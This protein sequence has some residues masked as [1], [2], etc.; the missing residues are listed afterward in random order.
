MFFFLKK[1]MTSFS[2]DED[3][4]NKL[5]FWMLLENQFAGCCKS[6]NP[7]FS[8]S[9]E[10]NDVDQKGK[11]SAIIIQCVC[12][13]LF[14]QSSNP[15]ERF[16]CER[17][18][19]LEKEFFTILKKPKLQVSP[20]Y[21][22]PEVLFCYTKKTSVIAFVSEI[23]LFDSALWIHI[24]KN[25][26]LT[27]VVQKNL[28]WQQLCQVFHVNTVYLIVNDH[29]TKFQ[30]KQKNDEVILLHNK[31]TQQKFSK[32]KQSNICW[33][34][35]EKFYV[36][37]STCASAGLGL[38]AKVHFS[39]GEIMTQFHGKTCLQ[40]EFEKNGE[41]NDIQ[42]EYSLS[43]QR[44]DGKVV[45]FDP[46]VCGKWNL[47]IAKKTRNC[48][49]FINEPP[50]H[51]LCNAESVSV[52]NKDIEQR[53]DIVATKNIS[54]HEEIFMLYNRTGHQQQYPV[55]LCCP[56][57]KNYCEKSTS[58]SSSLTKIKKGVVL[59]IGMTPMHNLDHL[60]LEAFIK[61]GWKVVCFSFL[62]QSN[63]DADQWDNNEAFIK[64]VQLKS[65]HLVDI[66]SVIQ[67]E[68][69][70]YVGTQLHIFF[71]YIHNLL[72][73]PQVVRQLFFTSCKD[74]L[75]KLGVT[76]IIIPVFSNFNGEENSHSVYEEKQQDFYINH[77]L[78]FD[79]NKTHLHILHSK[80]IV[81]ETSL[82]LMIPQLLQEQPNIEFQFFDPWN[83][84]VKMGIFIPS[85]LQQE[86]K[87]YS[88]TT[89]F[90]FLHPTFPFLCIRKKISK[91]NNNAHNF[92]LQLLSL[93]CTRNTEMEVVKSLHISDIQ[94]VKWLKMY[95]ISTSYSQL[96]QFVPFVKQKTR[97]FL[98]Q[99]L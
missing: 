18:L 87:Y 32:K 11:D 47:C 51:M 25:T 68:L 79:A 67:A 92:M 70:K 75:E 43:G 8:F 9:F 66:L 89:Y 40:E 73:C 98:A 86:Q 19:E 42:A 34:C 24:V 36:A 55:G 10:K 82:L 97:D 12:L 77:S 90:K 16:V 91:C 95:T 5:L 23:M 6:W 14:A 2:K 99:S 37:P 27:S 31:Q 84:D 13:Q 35:D 50:P 58:S 96:L 80:R 33:D 30:T 60:R 72:C 69:R 94:T 38:F 28:F 21:S 54:P 1:K 74:F 46:T 49:P 78:K 4:G 22:S 56:N 76:T 64:H 26:L 7:F 20:S 41:R 15:D 52:S 61:E 88:D 53:L 17:L 3:G 63:F 29:V 57:P 39:R 81:N 71:D 59:C 44:F 93:T 48:A 62:D 83:V 65:S 85:F 45:V